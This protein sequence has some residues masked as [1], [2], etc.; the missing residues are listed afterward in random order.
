MFTENRAELALSAISQGSTGNYFKTFII[1][2]MYHERLGVHDQAVQNYQLGRRYKHSL[3]QQRCLR[4]IDLENVTSCLIRY[5]MKPNL[6]E[7]CKE[8]RKLT[9]RAL[10]LRREGLTLETSSFESLY[11]GQFTSVINL[12][13]ETK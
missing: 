4:N 7:Y 10:A 8:I 3:L 12:V 2:L 6:D 1:Q 13:D 5:G 11:S 9:F